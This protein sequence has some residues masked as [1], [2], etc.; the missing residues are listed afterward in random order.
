MYTH[1]LIFWGIIAILF[2]GVI[3]YALSTNNGS[4]AIKL[5]EMGTTGVAGFFSNA[6][7]KPAATCTCKQFSKARQG[8]TEAL[9]VAID[10]DLLR[11]IQ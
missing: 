6:S 11:K 8:F 4:I 5:I 3:I 1:K 2:V 9:E 10:C 7:I